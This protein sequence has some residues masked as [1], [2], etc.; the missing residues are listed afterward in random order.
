MIS[1]PAGIDTRIDV[2]SMESMSVA[3]TLQN[4]NEAL[5][6]LVKLLSFKDS[7]EESLT[8]HSAHQ[9]FWESLAI[10]L[11][12]RALEFEEV[13]YAK[14]WAHARKFAR[15]ALLGAGIRGTKEDLNDV[16]ISHFSRDVSPPQREEH[17]K[18]AWRGC[19][20]T[21]HGSEAKVAKA[22]AENAL[23]I[24][25]LDFRS[26]MYCYVEG[27]FDYEKIQGTK[28]W[29]EEQA[30]K[31]AAIAKVFA[32]RSFKMKEF[33]DLE[34]AKYGNVGPLTIDELVNRVADLVV[35]RANGKLPDEGTLMTELRKANTR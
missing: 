35:A 21:L 1:V 20:F 3:L 18:V 2:H 8:T 25:F 31:V 9:C 7:L 4:G 10:D 6:D 34:K 24:S 17:A 16:V 22:T 32:D 5:Y 27:G 13:G 14:W 15:W 28:R 12:Y 11:K 30:A 26:L 23:A 33:T 19:L 29:L